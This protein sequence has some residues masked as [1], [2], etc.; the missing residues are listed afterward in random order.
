MNLDG[1]VY[2]DMFRDPHP[3]IG[4]SAFIL[5]RWTK[6]TIYA[7]S[8]SYQH[9]QSQS[10]HSVSDPRFNTYSTNSVYLYDYVLVTSKFFN[11]SVYTASTVD[12]TPAGIEYYV[13]T[14]NGTA[15]FSHNANTWRNSPNATTN[16]YLLRYNI[17]ASTNFGYPIYGY[18]P[19]YAAS[20]D[21]QT[22]MKTPIYTDNG[23]YFEIISGYPRNHHTHKR[24]M[25]AAERFTSYG[26]TGDLLTGTTITSASYRTGLQTSATTIN[27][28]GL[29]DGSQPVQA[30]Q[31]TNINFIQSNN[32]IYQ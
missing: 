19:R 1:E 4:E 8:G 2:F 31:V 21:Y 18:D 6:H 5:K 29:G 14:I 17:L 9:H 27:S 16:N 12:S 11:E 10:W 28:G 23:T 20:P 32:V 24:N 7:L 13:G 22:L 3:E 26:L 30:S 15:S 25:F